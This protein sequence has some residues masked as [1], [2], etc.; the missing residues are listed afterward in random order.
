MRTRPVVG[1]LEA[2]FGE[3]VDFRSFYIDAPS[4][5]T[6][7]HQYRFWAQPQVVL[8]DTQG[9]I[10][11]SRLSQLTYVQLKQDIEGVLNHAP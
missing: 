1:K 2:E 7:M 5:Q 8:V 4:S 9:K 3:H 11:Q 10:V 6:T